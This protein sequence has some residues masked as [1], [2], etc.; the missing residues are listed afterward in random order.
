M[1]NDSI[2]GNW[3]TVSPGEARE[4]ARQS[5]QFDDN[6]R[7]SERVTD[8]VDKALARP[9]WSQVVPA[10]EDPKAYI[11]GM[12]NKYDGGNFV[13]P[14]QD[15]SQATQVA[16]APTTLTIRSPAGLTRAPNAA[17]PSD[18][19]ELSVNGQKVTLRCDEAVRQGFLKQD[20]DGGYKALSS[21]DR[22]DA[23]QQAKH[24]QEEQQ[25]LAKAELP[26]L[27]ER[28]DE[29]DE[30]TQA[31]IEAVTSRVPGDAVAALVQDYATNGSLSA[32][33][34]ARVGQAAGF[35][36]DQAAGLTA[37]VVHG[38]QRQAARAVA[39]S[40]IPGEE[41]EAAYDWMSAHYPVEHRN[42]VVALAMQSD[43][44]GLKALAS[45]Y[46][47]WKRQQQS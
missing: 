34:V 11:N 46:A 6:R 35:S 12:V 15:S 40:G 17:Q 28:G 43:A 25:A 24:E 16:F 22:E 2:R 13:T 36:A 39:S 4:L 30:Q 7:K 21:D 1:P 37:S 5:E 41:A 47:A 10:G 38:L 33:N 29:P 45:K 42:A 27:R 20:R 44:K 3:T 23:R 18:L 8:A 19:L 14:A 32:A 26:A 9:D 31:S